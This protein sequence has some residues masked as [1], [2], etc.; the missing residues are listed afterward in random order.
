MNDATR[1]IN[2][3]IPPLFEMRSMGEGDASAAQEIF[4]WVFE[5]V[6]PQKA[7]DS[8]DPLARYV[9][10]IKRGGAVIPFEPKR[11]SK[12]MVQAFLEAYRT[13]SWS[14]LIGIHGAEEQVTTSW[15]GLRWL[16]RALVKQVNRVQRFAGPPSRL[17][18]GVGE[19][20]FSAAKPNLR[21]A[22]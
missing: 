14:A 22:P 8:V 5:K 15:L 3:T 11:S 2:A 1:Y 20:F 16:K 13:H 6:G 10:I 4:D 9:T 17:G 19:G 18:G 7:L 12:A 21:N